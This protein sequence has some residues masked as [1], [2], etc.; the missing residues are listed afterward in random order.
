MLCFV[1]LSFFSV[2]Y[3]Y[4]VYSTCTIIVGQ[5]RWASAYLAACR[6][7]YILLYISLASKSCCCCMAETGVRSVLWYWR[8]CIPYA[9]AVLVHS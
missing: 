9:V 3:L 4:C 1:S 6:H 5:L 2:L 7:I 8:V